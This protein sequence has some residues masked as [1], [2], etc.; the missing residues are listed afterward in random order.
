MAC[1]AQILGDAEGDAVVAGRQHPLG[2]GGDGR[3]DGDGKSHALA[4][5]AKS[6]RPMPIMASMASPQRMGTSSWAATLT[7]AQIRLA[8]HKEPIGAH[9]A[10]D[11]PQ[12]RPVLQGRR[13]FHSAAPP[14]SN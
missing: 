9:Q 7:A 3:G 10:Q 11:P 13:D 5:R 2:G 8:D 1:G 12:Q 4:T 14:F 6:T